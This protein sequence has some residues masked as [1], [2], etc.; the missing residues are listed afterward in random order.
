M[1][2]LFLNYDAALLLFTA[3]PAL[4]RLCLWALVHYR[5]CRHQRRAAR[6]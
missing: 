3:Y 4:E 2:T 5:V 6:R 1:L